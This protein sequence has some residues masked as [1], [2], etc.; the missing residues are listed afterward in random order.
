MKGAE[1][2]PKSDGAHGP[3]WKIAKG[4]RVSMSVDGTYE[5]EVPEKG[6]RKRRRVPSL[7][8]AIEAAELFALRSGLE[9]N[10]LE[11]EADPRRMYTFEDASKDYVSIHKANWQPSTLE[12]YE[13]LLEKHIL[14]VIGGFPID[15][16]YENWR[17]KVKALLSGMRASSQSP[18]SVEVAHCVVSGVF[19]EMEDSGR[20]KQNPA[21]GLLK[22]LLPPK[23]KRNQSK[24]DPFTA[25][26]RDRMLTA[27][28]QFLPCENALLIEV[29]TM[30]GMR[31][32]E[33]LALHV[34]NLDVS[35][36]QYHVTE[37]IR[38][39]EFGPPKS[40]ESRLIDLPESL[41]MKLRGHING[42]KEEMLKEGKSVG[43]LF[44][45]LT[46]RV[47]QGALKRACQAAKLRVRTPHDLRHT[48]ATMLLMVHISPAYVQKQLGHSSISITVDRYGHWIPGEGRKNLDEALKAKGSK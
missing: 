6:K 32:G 29:L 7:E 40:G 36:N 17:E 37:K 16:P 31:I 43:Y 18:K 11:P 22:R 30:S 20:V 45:R 41:I 9:L 26:D 8:R 15:L 27:A 35:N 21:S 13:G 5:L 33:G 3:I 4:V 34:D 48:Y 47:I 24:P 28:W 44:P 23:K 12:R 10:L 42:M 25:Q 38:R 2:Y 46:E 1:R 39:G 19:S 14:P